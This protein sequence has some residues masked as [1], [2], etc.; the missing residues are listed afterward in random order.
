M[1]NLRNPKY[2][3]V[4]SWQLFTNDGWKATAQGGGLM[5]VR[6]RKREYTW[7]TIESHSLPGLVSAFKSRILL[8]MTTKISEEQGIPFQDAY[9]QAC[10]I[11]NNES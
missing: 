1:I 8:L 10:E 2:V 6:R 11:F 3:I 7:G 9:K 5:A 4:D